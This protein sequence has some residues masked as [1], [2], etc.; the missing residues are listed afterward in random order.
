MTT[1]IRGILPVLATPFDRS[2]EI[3]EE[4]ARRLVRFMLDQGVHGLAAVGEASES[5]MLTREE[6]LRL[7][8][9]VFAEA[10]GRVPVIVG[11]SAP[12]ARESAILAEHAAS[13]GA[14]AV[15]LLPPPGASAADAVAHF[16]RV[17]DACGIPLMLQDQQYPMA[18]ATIARVSAEEPRVRYVKEEI[19]P[20]GVATLKMSEIRAAAGDDLLLVGGRGGQALVSELRRGAVASMPSCLGVPGLVHTYEAFA[21]GDL[22]TARATAAR[23]APV[24]LI[25]AQYSQQVVKAYLHAIGVFSTDLM[26]EPAG[27][28]VDQIDREE[29]LDAVARAGERQGAEVG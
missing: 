13:L 18:V 15:F 12:N 25:R 21:R 5:S 1:T 11:V 20:P 7:A 28:A 27:S 9:I 17:A 2:G 29:L 16:R 10:A 19:G 8:E 22:A 23:N 26:R 14:A 3:V 4:D 24:L 6:R